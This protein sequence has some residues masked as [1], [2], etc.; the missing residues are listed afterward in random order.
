LFSFFPSEKKNK[1]QS[2]PMI[3]LV[4][5]GGQTGANQAGW[6]AAQACGVPT[7]GWM[8]KGFLTARGS[9]RHFADLYGAC[10]MP[11]AWYP[12]TTERNVRDSDGTV[13]FG[14]TD[15]PG[16]KTTLDACNRFKRPLMLV[17]PH[18]SILPADV[19]IWLR[20]NS[21]IKRLN[22]AGSRES[23]NRGVGKRVERF[24]TVVFKR[25]NAR[26]DP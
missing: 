17:E 13:W 21:Q 19:V 2:V 23:E 20:R 6:R 1:K 10:E 11:T 16:A 9:Q 14:P 22:I 25:A 5:S 18:R 12:T 8:P 4:I 7:G 15:T 24:L 26:T 3:T